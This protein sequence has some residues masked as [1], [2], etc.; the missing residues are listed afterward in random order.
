VVRFTVRGAIGAAYVTERELQRR[1]PARK[2]AITSAYSSIQLGPESFVDFIK[3]EPGSESRPSGKDEPGSESRSSGKDEPGSES[4]SSGKD[5]PGSESRSSGENRPVIEEKLGAVSGRQDPEAGP[6]ASPSS[7]VAR[8]GGLV[9]LVGAGS[10]ERPYKGFHLLLDALAALDA[11]AGPDAGL[12]A[13]PG[14]GM[15]A[16]AVG[17]RLTIVGGGK[18]LDVLRAQARRLGLDSKVTFT[19][20]VSG[21]SV[22]RAYFDAAD[23]FVLS[24]LTEGLPRVLIEAMARGKAAVAANVGGVA[25]L[26]EA[27]A[28]VP[29]GDRAALAVALRR[30]ITEPDWRRKQ[31]ERNLAVSRRYALER[32]TAVR[33][34]FYRALAGKSAS[35]KRRDAARAR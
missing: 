17:W 7:G 20:Q 25:E 35:G 8:S 31:A 5:E 22:V 6:N 32:L 1:Y 14:T 4:R 30:A 15:R 16:E 19:G 24:S 9:R 29:A 21:P 23:L 26:V 34:E 33:E 28:M 27:E 13:G 10:L 2:G 18:E 11:E 12:T 3:D